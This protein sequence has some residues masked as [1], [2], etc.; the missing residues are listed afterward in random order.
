MRALNLCE[1]AI[2]MYSLILHHIETFIYTDLALN[3]NNVIMWVEITAYHEPVP[4]KSKT[5]NKC[6]IP[7]ACRRLPRQDNGGRRGAVRPH[8]L[9]HGG[10]HNAHR[11][12]DSAGRAW[13]NTSQSVWLV[14]VM[15]NV[16][17]LCSQIEYFANSFQLFMK[18]TKKL[19]LIESR[20]SRRSR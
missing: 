13:C 12:C 6:N 19:R 10:G 15:L 3:I 18:H 2:A 17:I 14:V 4:Y 20:P 5:T 9:R 8:A 16:E 1:I 11:G 7:H